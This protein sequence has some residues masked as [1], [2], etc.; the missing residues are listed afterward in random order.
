MPGARRSKNKS[1]VCCGA[2]R[3]SWH[4]RDVFECQLLRPLIG[5]KR[6]GVL[7]PFT[8]ADAE[9][10]ARISACEQ[11]LQQLGWTTARNL[12][13]FNSSE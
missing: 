1:P 4:R 12:H 11:S 7:V 8:A 10:K 5:M 3:R 2:Q 13:C 9:A 6:I